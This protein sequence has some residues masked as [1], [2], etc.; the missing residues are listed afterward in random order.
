[1]RAR[2]LGIAAGLLIVAVAPAMAHHSFAMFDNSKTITL[3]GTVK[4]FEWVNPHSWIHVAVLNKAGV[5][6]DW[7]F[8]MGSP[9]MLANN[10]WRKD[11]LHIGDKIT[12][13]ARPMRDGSHGGSPGMIKDAKGN[14]VGR[15]GGRGLNPGAPGGAAGAPGGY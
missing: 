13:S 15:C 9:G 8:E 7:A 1:M 10:G 4:E 12:V 14:C 6:E 11:T 2:T 5:P 3:T